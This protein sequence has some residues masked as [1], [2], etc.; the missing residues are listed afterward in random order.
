MVAAVH[1]IVAA[2]VRRDDRVLLV[3][4]QGPWDPEPSWML[5]GGRVEE[6]E[7]PT[8]AL[9]RELREETG[10]RLMGHPRVAF[11]VEVEATDGTYQATTFS[12]EAEGTLAPAD[13]DGFV[14]RAEWLPVADALDRLRCVEW[15]DCDPLERYLSDPVSDA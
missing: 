10:L 3:R 13:P 7:E 2:L 14:D 12:C 9:A 1:R 4:Q 11:D 8:D 5:P 15:Y 6:G